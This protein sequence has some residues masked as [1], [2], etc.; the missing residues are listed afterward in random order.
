MVKIGEFNTVWGDLKDS[1]NVELIFN[2]EIETKKEKI[3]VELVTKD[4]YNLFVNEEFVSY[5]PARTAKGY[6]R[7]ERLDISSYIT[8]G[9]NVVSVHVLS[10]DARSLHLAKGEPFFGARILADGEM[11]KDTD[12]FQCYLNTDRIK[13]VE[14]MSCQ[15]GFLEVYDVRGDYPE[16]GKVSVS[17]PQLL[18]RR[19]AYSKNSVKKASYVLSGGVERMTTN[20]WVDDFTKLLDT[21][22]WLEAYPR[23]E[24]DLVLS[25]EFVSFDYK[26]EVVPDGLRYEVYGFPHVIT[27]KFV[28]KV[29]VTE[30]TSVWVTFDDLLKDGYVRFNRE[31]IIHGLKWTLEPGEYTLYSQEVYA[32]KYIQLITDKCVRIQEVSIICVENPDVMEFK[33][34]PMEKALRTIVEAAQNS[35]AQNAYDLFTD[36]PTR[37]RSGWLCD[38]YFMGK[39]ERFFTGQNKVEK[40]FLENY[41]LYNGELFE[42]KGII[43]MCYPA[44]PPTKEEYIPAWILWYVLELEDYKKR[45]GDNE[46]V[47]HHRQRFADILDFFQGYENEYGLLENLEGWV[48]VEWSKATDFVDGVNIPTNI[49]YTEALRAIGEMLEKDELIEK[50][51]NLRQIIRDMAFDGE[52][53]RDNAIRVDGQLQMTQNVSEF[54][55]TI[56]AYFRLEPEGSKFYERFKERFKTVKKEVHPAA[57]FIG[58]VLRLMTLYDMGEY[59]LV[60]EECKEHFLEMAKLTGTLWEMFGGNASCNHGFGAVVGKVICEA[61][62]KLQEEKGE[63]YERS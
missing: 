44:Q 7:I 33:I 4:I 43:P 42:H 17:C 39:A 24:C 56:V 40:D 3:I 9:Q 38:S 41:L 58:S 23:K 30:R 27:G 31:R 61:I 22:E 18:E 55:Q 63:V 15:R 14:R 28:I 50:S 32:A 53:Y 8:D 5:G 6:A 26:K 62:F 48:F 45:T 34:P 16:I 1:K 60:L 20:T 19:T 51:A 37:E 46:F 49:L 47:E 54:N 10:N 11:I 13:K 36:C 2:C 35:L 52:V 12:D 29:K 21:G 59:K 57:L 25:E